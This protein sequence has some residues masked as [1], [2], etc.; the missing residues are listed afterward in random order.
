MNSKFLSG[1]KTGPFLLGL[2]CSLTLASCG[3]SSSNSTAPA[4]AVNNSV[5]VTVGFGPTGQAG[6]YVNGIFT[7]VNVC[8][9][10]T[11]NC[12]TINN[13]LVDTGSVGLRI[14]TSALG[15]VALNQITESGNA[16]EE[17]IQY[18]DTSYS[19][20]PMQ[21]ADVDIGGETASNIPVQLL[22]GTTFTVP[23]SCLTTPVNLALPNAGDEDTLASLGAN[24][25]LGIAG[26]VVDCGS[27]CSSN[28]AG[29]PYYI[30]PSGVC[31]EVEVATDVQAT[32]PIAAF[33]SS[34]KNG[35]MI[36]LPAVGATGTVS[37]SGTMNFGI[38]TQADNALG[39]ATIY[40]MDPCGDFPTVTY[41]G[42]TYSD[43]A[44]T[45]G[46]GGSGGFLDT[47]SNGLYVS[48]ASTL[49]PLGIFDCLQNTAGSG[50]YCV[51][52]G[53]ATLSNIGL[54]GNGNVGTGSISLSIADA[55]T[56]IKSNN[57]V[58]NNLGGDSGGSPSTDY[59]DLGLPF[60]LGRTIFIEIAG[61]TAPSLVNAPYGFVAF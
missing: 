34:D 28:I 33:T 42:I 60:F 56:L 50:F 20:G 44:C 3:S 32:N 24:G 57:A 30:C 54:A 43:T 14:L 15:S 22:G 18:G 10:G 12:T 26:S 55:S 51:T 49:A 9:H 4:S 48:D 47:G 46:A 45:T 16:I 17:C 61:G 52:G 58:F 8:Q 7:T 39:S 5:A 35:V 1:A 53:T 25:I 36:T 41:N 29:N 27:Y 6:G 2:I 59:F 13:V 31:E 40:A 37:V 11:S 23:S 19:W 38:A 21:L